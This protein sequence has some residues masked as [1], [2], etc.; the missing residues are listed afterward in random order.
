MD[1]AEPEMSSSFNPHGALINH[2]ATQLLTAD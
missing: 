2:N 1:A